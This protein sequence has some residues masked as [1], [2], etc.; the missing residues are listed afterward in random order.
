MGQVG[1]VV[2]EK[3]VERDAWWVGVASG[4]ELV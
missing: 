3:F 1:F 2:V 4:W